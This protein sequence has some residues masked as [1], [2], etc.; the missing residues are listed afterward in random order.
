MRRFRL[1]R[2]RVAAAALLPLAAF[3]DATRRSP[4]APDAR[5]ARIDASTRSVAIGDGLTLRGRFPGAANAPIE[6]RHRAEG[7]QQLAHGRPRAHRRLRALPRPGP[8]APQRLLARRARRARRRPRR[9]PR[10]AP[11]TRSAATASA[12]DGDTGERA[13]HGPL[14]NPGDGRRPSHARRA[15]GEGARRGQ[16]G[17]GRAPRRRP[18]RRRSRADQGRPRRP[19]RGR[20]GGARRPAPTRSTS[21]ARS[22]RLATGSRDRPAGSRSTAG[23]PRPG[24]GPASTATARLRR[25]ADAVDARR[26]PQDDA[27]R[28]EAAAALR[29][30][31]GRRAGDRPRALRGRPRVRPHQATKER[32]AFPTP[33]RC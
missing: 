24:T 8:A 30:A 19:L 7:A 10:T 28:D 13:G 14:A 3:T 25:D 31:H 6:I 4:Q 20:L 2:R 22:N 12:V 1:R 27:V 9:H 26:R 15:H 16:P 18:H 23:R 5:S 29:R 17:R 32:S 21:S 11:A 33:G